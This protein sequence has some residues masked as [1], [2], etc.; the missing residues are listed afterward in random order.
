[1]A[2]PQ[3]FDAQDLKRRM[4]GA[5]DALKHDFGGLRTGRHTG[6]KQ[7]GC[8]R[9]DRRTPSPVRQV[10][11]RTPPRIQP[12]VAIDDQNTTKR[13]IDERRLDVTAA[14]VTQ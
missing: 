7:H 6:R 11:H 2:Q 3:N 14:G 1:M 10:D 4:H 5:V 8:Q 12:V 9:T 13:L